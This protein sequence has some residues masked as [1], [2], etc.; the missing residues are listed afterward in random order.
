MDYALEVDKQLRELAAYADAQLNH[1]IPGLE[2]SEVYRPAVPPSDSSSFF[3][4]SME[5]FAKLHTAVAF[6]FADR[7][8][9][10]FLLGGR[11]SMLL[12]SL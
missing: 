5:S 3:S 6:L 1:G 8:P 4:I 10:Y 12:F 7:R 11:S 9:S 2:E